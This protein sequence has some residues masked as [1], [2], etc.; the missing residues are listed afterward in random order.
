MQGE[1]KDNNAGRTVSSAGDIDNDGDMDYAVTNYGS[2]TKYKPKGINKP[3][4]IFYGDFDGTGQS[5]IVEAKYENDVL[6]PVRGRSCSSHAMPFLLDKFN[7]FDS[8]ARASLNEIYTPQKL[9]S[10]KLTK[11]LIY[12]LLIISNCYMHPK[13]QRADSK[14]YHTFQGH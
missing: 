14:K 10:S 4:R 9:D 7:T 13:N 8:F 5:T 2:N 11:I 6:L 12:F 3:I 1:A